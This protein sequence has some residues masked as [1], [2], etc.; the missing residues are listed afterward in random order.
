MFTIDLLKGQGVPRKSR[1]AGMAVAGVAV[2]VPVIAAIAVFG[3]YLRNA[4]AISI[5]KQAIAGYEAK[6][7]KLSDAVKLHKSREQDK[8]LYI[9][10]LS[11]V[12]SS[13][14]NHTQWS[15]ILTTV[16]ENLPDAVVLTKLEVTEQHAKKRI[17]KKDDPKKTIDISVPVKTLKIN[18][19]GSPGSNCDE[20]IR[21]FRNR[22]LGSQAMRQ[23]LNSVNVA[24][25]SGTL[26]EQEVVCYEIDCVFKP[27]L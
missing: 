22:L 25:T 15:D 24:Q 2:A 11:E 9:N 21:D 26:A 8:S 13:I 10:S 4:I 7:D 3:C 12:K 23:T 20:A 27:S 1:P 16:V 5:K 14:V 18:V 19:A 6:L 17:P